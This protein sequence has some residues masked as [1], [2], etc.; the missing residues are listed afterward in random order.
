VIFAAPLVLLGL[1]A[2][3]GLYFLLRLTPPAA[4]R[5]AF[6]P[7]TLLRGLAV[8]ERTP[9]RMPLWLLLLRL[10]AAALLILGLA[11]PS[12]HP[13]PALPGSGPVLLV[14]DNGWA[15]AP[16]WPQMLDAA[17]QVIAAAGHENRQVALL[18]TARNA[19]NSPP[20]I[21]SVV[22]ANAAGQMLDALAPQPWPADR[23]GAAKALASAPEATRI[24]L[25]DGITDGPGFTGFIQALR[26]SR[27]IAPAVVAP[28]LLAPSLDE[29]G[30]L[31]AHVA[32]PSLGLAVLAQ[33]QASRAFARG[34]T[35]KAGDAV[36]DL[37]LALTNQITKLVLEAPPGAGNV[38]LLDNFAHGSVVGLA[39]SSATAETPFL[40]PLY[41]VS[42]AMPAGS[43]LVTGDLASLIAGKV[44]VIILADAA[45]SPAA[46]AQAQNWLASGGELI[47]FAG[48]IS[49]AVPDGLAPD[50]LLAG[51]RR[52]GGTLTWTTPQSLAPFP[53]NSPLAGLTAG[54]DTTVSR[55]ILADPTQL[56]PGTVWAKLAD[57]TPLVLGKAMGKGL[58]ISVLTTANADWS[59]LALSGIYP[60]ML[61]RLIALSHG[62]PVQPNQVMPMRWALTGFGGLQAPAP[63][64]PGLDEASLPQTI[65]SPVHPPGIY[66]DDGAAIALN[67]G[68]HITAPVAAASL[69]NAEILGVQRAPVDFGNLLLAAAILLLCLDLLLSLRLRGLIRLLPRRASPRVALLLLAL[70]APAFFPHAAKAQTNSAAIPPAALQT[71]LAYIKTGDPATDQLSADALNYLSALISARSSAQL[72]DPEAVSADSDDL[73]LYPMIYWPVLPDSA[74]P[75][76]AAC[77]ALNSYMQHGGL[78]LMDAQ[79]SDAGAPGSGAGFAP[80]ATAALA[81][82]TSCLD[83]PPLEP[84]TTANAIAHSFYIIQSF[85]GKFTGA[86]V[87]I[88]SAAA[89]DA[90]GVTPIIIGQNDWAGAW[91]RDADGDAEQTP[92]PGAEDQRVTADRFGT[93]LVIY[94][95]TGNYKSDQSNLPAF[96]DKL[97][98]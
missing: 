87:L 96:L 19:D 10:G 13:P 32:A 58:L 39:S 61:A 52:L 25:A 83:L 79:G 4:R 17:R 29:S 9:H 26:P 48:P 31:V 21:Q 30:R 42:R 3:P 11:G 38:Y 90:D 94:A 15:A 88:A 75:S 98:Q 73:D 91:A 41:F 77:A 71:E 45:L 86:P 72:G 27:S 28:L 54:N 1:A 51:D 43:Q 20:V 5:I 53:G 47:R 82:A 81:R 35:S 8:A 57:G 50:P 56:D 64:A 62:A 70:N 68:G 23:I 16:D 95:L 34:T 74:A 36:I 60:A 89:R 12:L 46:L 80:G 85:P 93:N 59:N 2:L 49:A 65:V 92:L 76:D 24:Y 78:L 14:I 40:G 37:P 6:P 55:Q 18:A 67:L 66:G 84:L 22:T 63:G 33:Q 97:G 44:D 69:P 7:L